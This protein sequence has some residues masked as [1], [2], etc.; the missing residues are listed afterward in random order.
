MAHQNPNTANIPR[1]FYEDGAVKLLGKEMREL[2]IAPKKRLLVGVDAEG[3]QLRILAHYIDDEE[4]T[5]ALVN[6]KK[7]DKSDPHSL[8]QRIL[9]SVCKS[10]QAAKRFIYALLLGAGLGKLSQVLGCSTSETEEAL[11][12]LL[13]RYTGFAELKQTRI[14]QDAK[15]GW[16]EGVDQRIVPILGDTEGSRK[17]LAMSGYLQNGEAV[18]VK[19]AAIIVDDTLQREKELKQ[20]MFVDIVHDELQSET[21]NDMEIALRVAKIKADAIKTAGEILKLKCPLAGS[22]WNDDIDD[23]TIGTTWYKTH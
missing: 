10:R 15:K 17:H 2:W 6:G 8:N 16:F 5:N 14:P 13:T 19:N 21:S 12:R 11:D 22:Y 9:G 23:Y 7:S 1:E 20:W 3:I 4:F 18:V